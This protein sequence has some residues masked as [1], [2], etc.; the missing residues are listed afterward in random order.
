MSAISRCKW[1]RKW[2]RW[3]FIAFD[4]GKWFEGCYITNKCLCN[5]ALTYVV[6]EIQGLIYFLGSIRNVLENFILECIWWY[7]LHMHISF[8]LFM[9]WFHFILVEL[10]LCWLFLERKYTVG[11]HNYLCTIDHSIPFGLSYIILIMSCNL[12]VDLPCGLYCFPSFFMCFG[13]STFLESYKMNV[14]VL[15][16]LVW[17]F[18]CCKVSHIFSL[19]HFCWTPPWDT[20]ILIID[21]I[22][23]VSP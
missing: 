20:G 10:L 15:L 3:W 11:W 12:T 14:Q 23:E 6:M 17:G 4:R 13:S 16:F 7:Y 1:G 8:W 22:K 18:I 19:Q 2:C 21:E 9:K 5:N